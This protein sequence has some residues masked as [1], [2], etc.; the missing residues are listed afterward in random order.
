[1]LDERETQTLKILFDYKHTHLPC[2]E[3]AAKINSSDQTARKSLH[4]LKDRLKSDSGATI[5]AKSGSGYQLT[6]EDPQKFDH[7]YLNE[8]KRKSILNDLDTIQDPPDR[9]VYILNQL[10]FEQTLPDVDG[11]SE[12]LRVSRSTISKDLVEIKKLIRPFQLGLESKKE[13]GD[14][15]DGQ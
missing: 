2:K 5:M 11:L 3:I 8:S 15:S 6:I 14:C 10:L 12:K 13:Q 1:M 9:Q 7:F 4:S